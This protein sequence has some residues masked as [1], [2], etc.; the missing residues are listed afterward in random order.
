MKRLALV[1]FSLLATTA[2]AQT[3][4][5]DSGGGGAAYDGGAV[6]N[7]FLAPV[8]CGATPG[9]AFVGRT[10][11]GLCSPSAG[12]LSLVVPGGTEV[13][14]ISDTNLDVTTSAAASW[15]MEGANS[16]EF[17]RFGFHQGFGAGGNSEIRLENGTLDFVRIISFDGSS[18]STTDFNPTETIFSD[19]IKGPLGSVTIS[20]LGPSADPDN[21]LR[22]INEQ[23]LM[24][25]KGVGA[26]DHGH[27]WLLN[28][29][30][31]LRWRDGVAGGNYGILSTAFTGDAATVVLQA[32]DTAE[33]YDLTLDATTNT[34]VIDVDDGSDDSTTTFG[35]TGTTFT[36]PIRFEGATVDAFETTLDV[37]DPTSDQTPKLPDSSG[38]VHLDGALN[39]MLEE[40]FCGGGDSAR[41]IGAL[42]WTVFSGVVIELASVGGHPCLYTNLSDAA[43]GARSG[44]W[45]GNSTGLG[46]FIVATDMAR[47]TYVFQVDQ[48]TDIIVQVG[49]FNDSD[50]ANVTDGVYL[51]FDPALDAEFNGVTEL[52]DTRT[53]AAT[54]VTVATGVWYN[55]TFIRLG[56]GN[57]EFYVGVAGATPVLEV[58]NTTNLPTG[59]TIPAF[60]VTKTTATD[61]SMTV[62]YWS[63]ESKTLTR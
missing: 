35:V 49:L 12:K 9:Y 11:E 58:T 46:G 25:N 22:F 38:T 27:L 5:P 29:G 53:A 41:R 7:P 26:V 63:A 32:T 51:E 54:T 23:L 24:T 2:A 13:F 31:E 15:F 16:T 28:P 34:A 52:A 37:V 6:T 43:L 19:P 47:M 62:D 33:N 21:G 45:L 59:S 14:Q 60:R 61:K 18:T 40:E 8:G 50:T 3:F 48:L 56:N 57:W 36:D 55:A 4:P 17:L 42:G 20:A 39:M 44:L 10:A 30:G 1:V